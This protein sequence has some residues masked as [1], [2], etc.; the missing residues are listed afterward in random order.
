MNNMKN[1]IVYLF[2]IVVLFASCNEHKKEITQVVDKI[3]NVKNTQESE[4]YT[5][6]KNQCY[7]CHSI[8]APSHD[9][10]IAPPMI[11]VKKRYLRMYRDKEEFVEAVSKWAINPIEENAIM[12]GAVS[13]FKVMPKQSFNEAELRKIAEY[14]FDNE[15]EKPDWFMAHEKEMHGGGKGRGMGRKF[16]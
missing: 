8:N 12:R 16:D 5:L 3:P 9:D 2:I 15:L 7:A 13:Q 1:N 11:A 4:A 10:I 14:M 6:L